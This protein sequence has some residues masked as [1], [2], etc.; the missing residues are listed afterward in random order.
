METILIL[1]IALA[2]FEVASLLWGVNSTDGIDSSEWEK[3]HN[4]LAFH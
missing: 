3:R 4:W 2:V 1:L